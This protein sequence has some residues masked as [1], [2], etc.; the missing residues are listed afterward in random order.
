VRIGFDVIGAGPPLVFVRGWLSDIEQMADS[1]RING[2]FRA[3]SQAFTVVRFDVRTQ[4]VSDHEIDHVDLDAFVLDVEAVVNALSLEDVVLYGQ[5]F[6]GPIALAYAAR[7]PYRIERII[8]DG[9]YAIAPPMS[10]DD[11]EAFLQTLERLWPDSSALLAKM[12]SPDEPDRST[13]DWHPRISGSTVAMLY[14]FGWS[15]DIRSLLPTVAMPALVIHRRRSRSIPMRF[16]QDLAAGLPNALFVPL[17]G[18]MHNPWDG[19]AQAVLD[20]IGAFTGADLRLPEVDRPAPTPLAILFTDM[21]AS[22]ALTSQLGDAKAQELV[23]THDAVVRAAVLENGGREVKHTG[24][25]IMASFPSISGALNGA[26][27]IQ[28][29]LRVSEAP[30]RVRI[31]IDAGEPLEQ[32]DDLTGTVVQSARRIVDKAEPGQILVSDVVR[33]LVAGK[34]YTFV[35]QGRLSLKGIP[36]RVRLYQVDWAPRASPAESEVP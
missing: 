4:G 31:G 29:G 32:G 33:K 14:R 17:E 7:H 13:V 20:A 18:A 25:G 9:T 21:E 19:D 22:T 8:L 27:D 23:R 10:D 30:F 3:L 15:I 2:F 5:C 16:G 24:D 34:T 12:T 36:E 26:M 35:D 6:G 1:P 11:R 28:K